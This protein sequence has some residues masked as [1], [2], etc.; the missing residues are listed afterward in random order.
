MTAPIPHRAL[1]VF[2]VENHLD[3]RLMLTLLMELI[4]CEVVC[5]GSKGE[6]L[7]AVPDA[8]CDVLVSDIG[9]DDGTGWDLLEELGPAAPPYAIAM[10]GFGMASDLA[11]SKAAGFRQHLVKPMGQEKLESYLREA[12]AELIGS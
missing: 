3:S 12:E 8:H 10:S 1:R 6:A 4:G 5:A 11:R 2:L 9:L 7:A